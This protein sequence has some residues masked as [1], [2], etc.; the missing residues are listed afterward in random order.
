MQ[1]GINGEWITKSS[2]LSPEWDV[3]VQFPNGHKVT[4]EVKRDFYFS[5][6][7]NLLLE[8]WSNVEGK[9]KGWW[10]KTKADKLIVFY[11]DDAFYSVNTSHID[12]FIAKGCQ[13]TTKEIEQ[14]TGYHTSFW[15]VNVDQEIVQDIRMEKEWVKRKTK[16]QLKHHKV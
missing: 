10:L 7:R 15:L 14:R 13:Y 8:L 2:G 4:Y 3:Q 11:E 1:R 12:D 6:T 16:L 9:G 5:R